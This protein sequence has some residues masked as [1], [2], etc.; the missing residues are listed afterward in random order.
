[1]DNATSQPRSPERAADL[2]QRHASEAQAC[3]SRGD[4]VGALYLLRREAVHHPALHVMLAEC[5]LFFVGDPGAIDEALS[6]L[7]A[8]EDDEPKASYL[9]AWLA[10]GGRVLPV[11]LALISSRIERAGAAGHPLAL[12]A[13]AFAAA[14]SDRGQARA[15]L[16]QAMRMGDPIAGLLL[17]ER[18]RRGEGDPEE[19]AALPALEARLSASGYPPLP[20]IGG[21]PGMRSSGGDGSIARLAAV[22]A[23]RRLAEAHRV[24]RID[25]L[26]SAD[27]CLF[28]VAMARPLLKRSAV[29]DPLSGDMT[30]LPVRTS[31]DAAFDVMHEDVLLRLLILRMARA[32]GL[33]PAHAEPLIVLNYR[34]G[35]AY[36]PH[37]D[38]LAPSALAASRPEAGQRQTTV[39]AYL[40]T[41][42]E[43]GGTSFP[44]LGLESPAVAGAAVVFDN[45]AADGSPEP[46]SL[47]AG[48]PVIRGEKWLATLWLRERPIRDF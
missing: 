38:Y 34:P 10:L 17:A 2:A 7:L 37:R 27:E 39:C 44:D 32:A 5:L 30:A 48:D 15:M 21:A 47:H 11:D 8:A 46:L 16:A 40:N 31:S 43:G 23:A 18:W 36:R 45:L 3:L 41:V 26:M 1:M 14:D 33:E 13:L 20:R 29:H 9:L 19:R 6:G 24:D 35:E 12:R 25:G 22:S 28:L 4:L 42:E